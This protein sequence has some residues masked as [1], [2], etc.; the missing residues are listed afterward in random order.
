LVI[1]WGM[2]GGTIGIPPATGSADGAVPGAGVAPAGTCV[3]ACGG[4][5]TGVAFPG[6]TGASAAGFVG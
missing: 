2:A 3:I 4:M 5:A 1:D 6:A